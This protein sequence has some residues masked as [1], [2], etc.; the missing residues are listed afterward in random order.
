MTSLT[1]SES[2]TTVD[3]TKSDPVFVGKEHAMVL[4]LQDLR[5]LPDSICPD[6]VLIYFSDQFAYALLPY[7]NAEMV[8]PQ[9][10]MSPELY[11]GA[12]KIVFERCFDTTANDLEIPASI[13]L[14]YQSQVVFER[15]DS[16]VIVTDCL[17]EI[18][19]QIEVPDLAEWA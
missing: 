17:A 4:S 5:S 13:Q 8:A 16:G 18:F 3:S 11:A 7:H 12:I 14:H 1:L 6:R 10:S 9:F 19:A 2:S 15:S